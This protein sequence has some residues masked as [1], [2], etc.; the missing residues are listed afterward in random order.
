MNQE[1]LDFITKSKRLPAAGRGVNTINDKIFKKVRERL[2]LS[3][4]ELSDKLIKETIKFCNSHIAKYIFENPEGLQLTVGNQLHGVLAISKHMPKE[5]R[6]NKFEKLEEIDSFN[7]PEWKKNILK[8]RYNTELTRR[9][10]KN[11][12]DP[13]F[14]NVHSFFY[15]YRFIWFNHRNTKLKK[16]RAYE[17]QASTTNTRKLYQKIREGVDFFELHFHNFYR[18]KIKPIL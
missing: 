11:L 13:G 17:F 4:E 2:S 7:M 16:A 18:Y 15:T 10:H 9:R 3:E 14:M 1:K 12:K 8:K 6:E 5:L